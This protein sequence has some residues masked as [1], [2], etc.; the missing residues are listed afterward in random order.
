MCLSLYWYS[1]A[2][3]CHPNSWESSTHVCSQSKEALPGSNWRGSRRPKWW[4]HCNR[5]WREMISQRWP[6][7]HLQTYTWCHICLYFLYHNFNLFYMYNYCSTTLQRQF[8]KI[9]IHGLKIQSSV[10]VY[11]WISS[12][13]KKTDWYRYFI[14]FVLI[15]HIS[16]S[17]I[18]WVQLA[19]W[20]HLAFTLLIEEFWFIW[21]HAIRVVK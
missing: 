1:Y 20:V 19:K 18:F 21:I 7:Q 2:W 13:G 4:W 15:I 3:R 11:I 8:Q 16:I 12:H 10:F 5:W 17:R 9:A 6:D 14:Y